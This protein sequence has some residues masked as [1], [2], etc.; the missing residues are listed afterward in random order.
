MY[1]VPKITIIDNLNKA[2]MILK[3]IYKYKR[4]NYPIGESRDGELDD[5]AYFFASRKIP[6]KTCVLGLV[7]IGEITAY[8]DNIKSLT[9]YINSCINKEVNL[10]NDIIKTLIKYEYERLPIDSPFITF[11]PD[12]FLVFFAERELELRPY[13]PNSYR[14]LGGSNSYS[15]NI[16]TLEN[17]KNRVV[18]LSEI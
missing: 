4:E 17:Y 5:L 8:D 2:I 15:K 18:S 9:D 10:I 3:L 12:I 11:E 6:I 13:D 1:N 16:E 14:N 7:L